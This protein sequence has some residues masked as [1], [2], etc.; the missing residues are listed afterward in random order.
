M[1]H[2][3]FSTLRICILVHIA[4]FLDERPCT[5]SALRICILVH[6]ALFLC[7][8]RQEAILAAITEKDAHIALLEMA[9]N[10]NSQNI[11]E[12]EKLTRDKIGLQKQLKELVSD[13]FFTAALYRDLHQKYCV[14]H[15][16]VHEYAQGIA[17]A[18]SI[19]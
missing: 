4:L 12:V 3:A 15:D 18:I 10:K 8:V 17:A 6:I 11:E 13:C 7:F 2:C 14:L 16:S 1:R 5:C 9:P 19:K